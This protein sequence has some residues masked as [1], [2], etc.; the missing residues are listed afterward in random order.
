[1]RGSSKLNVVLKEQELPS[2]TSVVIAK[3][4]LPAFA[5][6]MSGNDIKI[7]KLLIYLVIHAARTW[8]A[9]VMKPPN[10][11]IDRDCFESVITDKNKYGKSKVL[12][13]EINRN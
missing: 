12:I 9:V 11:A 13:A 8:S 2:F 6:S 1:M 7:P 3:D 4:T 10:G 5:R